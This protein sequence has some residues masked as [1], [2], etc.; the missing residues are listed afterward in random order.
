MKR[1]TLTLLALWAAPSLAADNWSIVYKSGTSVMSEISPLTFTITNTSPV[2]GHRLNEIVLQINAGNYDLDGAVAPPGWRVAKV[3]RGLKKVIFDANGSCP[4]LGLA[5]GQSAS[6][7][8][9][10]IGA[11]AT[12]DQLGETFTANKTSATE[13]CTNSK[14]GNY[15]GNPVWN[16]VGLDAKVLVSPRT[17][18][19]G[20][21]VTVS[22]A[23]TNR[24]ATSTGGDNIVTVSPTAPS[25]SGTGG[26]ALQ[27]GPSPPSLTLTTD[28]T[29]T[30]N[31]TYV[32]TARGVVQ[33]SAGA[34][35]AAATVTSPRATSLDTDVGIFPGQ[36]SISPA[37]ATTGSLVTV[38]FVVSNNTT[39]VYTNVAPNPL[40]VTGTATASLVSG[41][42][43]ASVATLAP[44]NSTAFKWTYT[45][46]GNANDTFQFTGQ[47]VATRNGVG[48]SSDPVGSGTGQI[49]LYGVTPSPASLLTGS[50]NRTISYTIFN[51][52]S[53]NMTSVKLITPDGTIFHTPAPGNTTGWTV[54]SGQR[55]FTWTA[56][57][58]ADQLA[59]GTSKTFSVTYASVGPVTQT[60]TYSHKFVLTD[61][62]GNTS[63]AEGGV[64]IFINRAMPNVSALVAL[65]RSGK[66]TLIW[67]NPSDHDGVLVLR[68]A[69]GKGPVTQVPTLGTQYTPGQWL[70]TAGA[71][72]SG[73]VIYTDTLSF[74]SALD[75]TSVTNGQRYDYKVF[76]HD[77]FF[78]YAAGNVPSSNGIYGVPQAPGAGVPAWCYNTGAAAT[79]QPMIDYGAGVYTAGNAGVV[80]GV[81]SSPGGAT[82]GNEKWR[83]VTLSGPVQ[84]RFQVVPLQGRSGTFIVVGDQAGI[85]RVIDA[86]TGVVV[87]TMNPVGT[88]IQA[89]PA[90][91]LR[92][93]TNTAFQA[94]WADDLLIFASRNSGAANNV[95]MAFHGSTGNQA[96]SYAPGDLQMI[97]GGMA[98]DYNTNYLW[99]ASRSGGV[100][101]VRVIDTLTGARVASW[102][103]GDVDLPIAYDSSSHQMYV[104]ST[105][106][107][108]SGFDATLAATTQPVW[109]FVGTGTLSSYAFPTGFSFIA[110]QANS[111]Q[112]YG[113]SG[114]T[115]TPRWA[116]APAITA[117]TGVRI[118]YRSPQ[119]LYVGDS[120]GVL[121][122]IDVATGVEDTTK[123]RTLGL[124]GLGTPTIDP[125][126]AGGAARLYVNSLDGRL[127]AVDVPY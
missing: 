66:N 58:T 101:S 78:I 70:G 102:S 31:Y 32:A 103:A 73:Q 43:P 82:D 22:V 44:G 68:S 99:V 1:L 95:V 114:T 40:T 56:N 63:R 110:S 8:M 2:T 107:V 30:F 28:Q 117:P 14:F 60:T 55:G 108:V 9:N 104:T 11:D 17:L 90:V 112:W 115:V 67:S 5:S 47:A 89:Q 51:G 48:I 92:Q 109:Q 34:Q 94:K 81:L 41:P 111:L 49:I 37:Q 24:T 127:C 19:L 69:A 84:G 13:T 36:V 50:T 10:V 23:V 38:L 21:T 93:Y 3:D 26:F 122:Q 29:G 25:M 20:S 42:T 91:A 4:A 80:A 116:T 124:A 77:P 75:D 12:T 105:T 88:S 59:V 16:R 45:V 15:T 106:G 18:D 96:W 98:F 76:N 74:A 71:T 35:N 61:T 6:F 62:D 27:S 64:T 119:K 86:T 57:T 126:F 7:T 54:K 120:A 125:Y 100:G 121:H 97:S 79:M 113:V 83:P 87:L 53:L 123:R 72:G 52:G 33:F 118:D 46:S 85:P 39:D 65:S